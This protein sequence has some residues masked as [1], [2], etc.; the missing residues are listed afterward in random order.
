MIPK[1]R[2]AFTIVFLLKKMEI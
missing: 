1:R 2:F